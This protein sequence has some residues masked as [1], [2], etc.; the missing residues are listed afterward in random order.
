MY[1]R[2]CDFDLATGLTSL[3]SGD[4]IESIELNPCDKAESDENR[5]GSDPKSYKL[6]ALSSTTTC[7]AIPSLNND[8]ARINGIR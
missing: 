2:P 4:S 8:V 6:S 7:S 3:G 1:G 5:T